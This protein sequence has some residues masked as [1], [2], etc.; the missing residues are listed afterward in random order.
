MF[1]TND[2]SFLRFAEELAHFYI[3]RKFLMKILPYSL[4]RL[5]RKKKF[6]LKMCIPEMYVFYTRRNSGEITI[7]NVF[8]NLSIFYDVFFVFSFLF[9]LH[10]YNEMSYFS[11]SFPF[12]FECVIV[13]HLY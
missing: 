9:P 6:F 3:R 7:P 12:L 5:V 1:Y 2:T 13:V 4:F 8:H 10:F 11:P